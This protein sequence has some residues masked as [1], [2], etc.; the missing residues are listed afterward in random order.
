M[1]K[2]VAQPQGHHTGQGRQRQQAAQ[3]HNQAGEAGQQ[4][5]AVQPI[6]QQAGEALGDKCQ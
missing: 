3:G 6:G 4:G 1:E 2:A 5:M